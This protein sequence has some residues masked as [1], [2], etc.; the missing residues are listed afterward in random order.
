MI[1]GKYFN[2]ILLNTAVVMILIKF[3]LYCVFLL[4]CLLTAIKNTITVYP[5]CA[6]AQWRQHCVAFL[7]N[8]S[9]IRCSEPVETWRASCRRFVLKYFIFLYFKSLHFFVIVYRI[10][11]QWNTL[12]VFMTFLNQN[13]F[14]FLSFSLLFYRKH[15]FLIVLLIF[16]WSFNNFFYVKHLTFAIFCLIWVKKKTNRL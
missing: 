5:Y 13:F 8:K 12:I 6:E 15:V 3:N 7:S 11:P 1:A 9:V 2:V 14:C 4:Y 10:Q 16:V